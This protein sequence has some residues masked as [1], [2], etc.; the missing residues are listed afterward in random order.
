MRNKNGYQYLNT[1]KLRK[2]KNK[3]K[4]IKLIFLRIIILFS[5]IFFIFIF[6][7][8]FSK[9]TKKKNI[10]LKNNPYINK[11]YRAS[12]INGFLFWNNEIS[13]NE[14]KVKEEIKQYKYINLSFEN[15]NDFIKRENPLITLVIT[16]YNQEEF[17]YRVYYSIQKQELKDIEIIFVDDASTDNSSFIIKKLMK[18]DKRIVYLKNDINRKAFYSRNKGVLNAKGK[19][20]LVIDPDDIILNNILIKAYETAEKF[21]LDIVRF[22]MMKGYFDSP[23]LGTRLKYKNGIRRNNS[24]VRR[25]FYNGISM[26]IC[27]KL[28][29][30]EVFVKSI[31]FI[32]PEFYYL[33][34]H[35]NDDNTALFGITHFAESIGFLEQIGYFYIARTPG[36][37]HYGAI[38]RSNDFI[39]S[40]CN[41]MKYFYYQSDNN[42][43]EKNNIAYNY[44]QQSYNKFSSRIQYL[45]EGFDYIIDVFNSYLNSSFFNYEQKNQLNEIKRKIIDRKKDNNGTLIR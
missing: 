28:I 20:L 22:Y 4:I 29:R 26:S 31:K 7:K 5:T 35:I 12:I 15:K 23:Y 45:T 11:I 13:L 2:K 19:Y 37:N 18:K 1:N 42:I 24:E 30:T 33:D 36:P 14:T 16:I 40:I 27:D 6:I 10:N 38:K 3:I 17:I 41:I 44:F 8:I 9:K 43:L 25:F 39:I 34:Y 21:N 32:K